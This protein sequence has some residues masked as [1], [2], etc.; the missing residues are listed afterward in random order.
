MR[1]RAIIRNINVLNVVLLAVIAGFAAYILPP[2]LDV[3]ATYTPPAAKKVQETK[4]EKA[5]APQPPSAME[6]TVVAE[7]NVF[8]PGRKIPTEKKEEKQLPK[9]DF[10]LF[11]TVITPDT[12][13]AFIEDMKAPYTSPGRG[14]RQRA[15]HLGS[16]LSGFT[17]REVHPDTVVMARGEERIELKVIDA[18]KA[19]L[20]ESEA[21]AGAQKKPAAGRAAATASARQARQPAVNLL[22]GQ[23]DPAKRREYLRQ[24]YGRNKNAPA[25]SGSPAVRQRPTTRSS[26]D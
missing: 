9:P 5:A 14:K 15:L 1:L 12:S 16:V 26:G 2:L 7:Q 11:G 8:N 21:V 3:Q 24:V 18:S 13:V 6:Y 19:K 20:R 25:A 23:L 17:L 4:E 10:V 22:G